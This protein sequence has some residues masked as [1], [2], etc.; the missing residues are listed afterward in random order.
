MKLP[1]RPACTGSLLG[2]TQRAPATIC[3]LPLRT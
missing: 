3:T 1:Q 2:V